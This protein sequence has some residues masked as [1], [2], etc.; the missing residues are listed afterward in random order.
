MKECSY[1]SLHGWGEGDSVTD[2]FFVTFS[3]LKVLCVNYYDPPSSMST[4]PLV[5]PTST[6]KFADAISMWPSTFTTSILCAIMDYL[7]MDC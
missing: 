3:S 2:P 4:F 5:I 6:K 7:F 1:H